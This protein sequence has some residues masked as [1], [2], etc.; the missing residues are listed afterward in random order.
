MI[1]KENI[2]DI[3]G[4]SPMQ[5]SMLFNHAVDPES[6]AYTEQFDFR[7]SGEIDP[8]RLEWAL[9]KLF[10]RY[11]IL[12]TIFSYRQTDEPRQVVLKVR[13]PEWVVKDFRGEPVPEERVKAFKEA[14]KQR[15]FDL[16]RDVL[17]RGALLRTGEQSWCFIFSF[18]HILMDGWSLAPLFQSFF[19]LYEEGTEQG[20]ARFRRD[21]HPYYEYI[22]WL[23]GQDEEEASR[24]WRQYLEGYEKPVS[25]PSDT[26]SAS[27][28][29]DTHSFHLPAA[30]TERLRKLARSHQWTVNAIFQTAW[31]L[32]LQKYNYTRD[33]VFG[34]V[35]SG[36]PPELPGVEQMVGLFIN[37]LP[38]RVRTE[39]GD[40]FSSLCT[41][42]QRESF[43][44]SSFE[45][46]PLYQIQGESPLKNKLLNHVVAF[47]NYPLAE[48]LQRLGSNG[49]QPYQIEEVKVFEQTNYDFHVVVNP[50]D[51]IVI[52]FAYNGNCFSQEIVEGIER[53]FITLLES[54]CHDPEAPI[55]TLRVCAATDQSIVLENFNSGRRPYPADRTVDQM[56]REVASTFPTRTALKWKERTFTYEQLDAWSDRLAAQLASKGLGPNVTA[57]LFV[58]RSPEM[59]AGILA[60]LKTGAS[61][62]PLDTVNTSER[63]A[64]IAEDAD[65]AIVCTRS[66]LKDNVPTDVD[67]F[68]LDEVEGAAREK[69]VSADHGPEAPAYTMYTSGSTGRPKGCVITHRNILNLVLGQDYVDFGPHQVI[70]QTG[71]P[72]FDA[73]TFEIWGALLHGGTL[74]LIEEEDIL[75]ADAL[76]GHIARHGV[77]TMWLTAPLFNRLCDQSPHLFRNLKNLLVG[78]DTLSVPHIKRVQEAN[79]D[80]KIV[81]GYGPTENTTF[82]TTHT[83]TARDIERERIPIGRPLSN[84]NVYIVDRGL[85][86]LPVGAIGELCVGGDGVSIGYHNRAELTTQRFLDDPF[87]AGGRLYRTGDL[88]RWLA[89]GTI[90]Y[91]GRFDSQVKIRGYRVELGEIERVMAD[92]PHLQE[93]TVQVRE[94]G[95]DKRICAYY[96]SQ[97]EVDLDAWKGIL[98]FKLPDYMIPD[99]FIKM[100]SL[101]LTVNGKIDRQALPAPQFQRAEVS[102]AMRPLSQVEKTVATICASVLGIDPA[103]ISVKE[104][105]FDLGANSLNMMTI[106]VRL[107]KAF[108]RD[109]P[110]TVLFEHPSIAQIA[111]YLQK[112]GETDIRGEK[113]RKQ[114]MESARGTL[115]KTQSLIQKMGG[116][117]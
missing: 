74:V 63:L 76:E 35:V 39:D 65:I 17:C 112:K 94:I 43:N 3:Y 73:C 14:D 4:L 105:F 47:E 59:V 71:S 116:S 5:K 51:A 103:A 20:V 87:V 72:A 41:K 58:P 61:Y 106:N 29:H 86:L 24:Y 69:H 85:N 60:I 18:H 117:R 31:G 8:P 21:E 27:Y 28:R 57:G 91:L 67:V 53:S 90:D 12:R 83:V 115:L 109:I 19:S 6:S 80:L 75:D 23:Q 40:S 25:L 54:A 79:P 93:V 107:K 108:K 38:L 22:R 56:F 11:D 16:S 52:N 99:F 89:D 100:D 78:G 26:S 2:Q 81:N 95:E 49:E 62:V 34:N 37:T 45:Y 7:I 50:G 30:L 114:E 82:S 1:Q 77:Q 15:G 46:Y 13:T 9:N 102:S 98:K 68:L 33:V 55:E 110:L 113:A 96:T 10:E 32:L 84:R 111:A 44:V 70:L 101:P 97:G 48:Q 42:V 66:D 104:N 36:R 88:A 64:F 92:L